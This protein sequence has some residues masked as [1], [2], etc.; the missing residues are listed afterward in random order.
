LEFLDI[1]LNNWSM[2]IFLFQVMF[3]T[4][5]TLSAF[6]GIQNK[7]FLLFVIILFILNQIVFILYGISTGQ[8]GFILLV[9][10]Q[11]FLVLMTYIFISFSVKELDDFE[12]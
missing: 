6:G 8:I 10:F 4:S 1:D 11:L 5:V 7:L 12:D 3:Y 9:V 2:I